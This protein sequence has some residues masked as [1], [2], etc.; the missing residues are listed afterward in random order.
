MGQFHFM[1]R[2]NKPWQAITLAVITTLVAELFFG[3]TPVS[4]A[5]I[6]IPQLLYY[7][8]ASILIR[9]IARRQ[10]LPWAGVVLLGLAFAGIEEGLTLSLFL[11]PISW[12]LTWR[13]GG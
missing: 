13:R 1:K 2:K 6:L 5:F 10:N 12:A 9:E 11:I 4:R 8:S 3:T 7:G